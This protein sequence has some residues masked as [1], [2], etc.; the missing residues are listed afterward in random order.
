MIR[1]HSDG[2]AY[3]SDLTEIELRHPDNED[4]QDLIRV[5]RAAARLSEKSFESLKRSRDEA[6]SE[7]ESTFRMLEDAE[8]ERD[9]AKGEIRKLRKKITDALEALK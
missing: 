2:T 1:V 4:V 3:D 9:D 8:D 6:Q 5:I 7:A